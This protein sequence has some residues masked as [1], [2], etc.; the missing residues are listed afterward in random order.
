MDKSIEIIE[1]Y[2]EESLLNE[3][4]LL[5][6]ELFY[7]NTLIAKTNHSWDNNI[8]KDSDPIIIYH[9]NNTYDIFDK[10]KNHIKDKNNI[11]LKDIFFY[12]FMQNSHIPWHND[13][14]HNGG[15]TIYLNSEWDKDHGGIFLFEHDDEIKG[16]YPSNNLAVIQRG[17]VNHCVAPTTRNSK[18]RKTIQIFF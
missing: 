17:G 11:E 12:N 1:N 2:L 5:S 15:L 3:C 13:G 18:I 7:C 14:N 16:V 4:K 9:I 6:N 10:I 8:V